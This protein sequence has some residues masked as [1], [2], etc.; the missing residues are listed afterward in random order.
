MTLQLDNRGMISIDKLTY[1]PLN[2]VLYPLEKHEADIQLLADKL[3]EEYVITGVP[4]H[5][6]IVICPETGIIFSG[7][8][9][10][11]AAKRKNYKKQSMNLRKKIK[12]KR[13]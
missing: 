8:F 12:L 11:R 2:E 3:E 9:R 10:K 1:H 5:T 13:L 7:N 6:P 4:N